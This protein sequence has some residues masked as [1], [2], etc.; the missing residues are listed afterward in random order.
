MATYFGEVIPI[1]SR[2]VDDEELD[3]NHPKYTVSI[4]KA[5]E[6]SSCKLMIFS[7]GEIASIFV[8][9]Y[10]L[11]DNFNQICA[12]KFSSDKEDDESTFYTGMQRN[13]KN[14]TA[15]SVFSLHSDIL[16][17]DVAKSVPVEIWYEVTELILKSY[18][19]SE[20]LVLTSKHMATFKNESSNSAISEK[21]FL[22]SLCTSKYSC[23]IPRLTSPNFLSNLPAS[24]L[25]KCEV[26]KL[27]AL[28][29]VNYVDTDAVD[30]LNVHTFEEILA[31]SMLSKVPVNADAK[32]KVVKFVKTAQSVE[33]NLYM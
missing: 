4:E 11:P 9:S 27:P 14:L 16:I 17:C 1:S 28:C 8:K 32:A 6:L 3:N 12:I 13:I 2:A 29:V 31:E 23:N 18:S 15:A 7:V 5:G 33:S 21:P 25:L 10:F 22:K 19:P 20:V 26:T 30:F 24:V